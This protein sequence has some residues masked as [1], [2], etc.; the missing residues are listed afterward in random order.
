[1]ANWQTVKFNFDIFDPIKSPVESVLQGLQAVESVLETLLDILKP[2][3]LDIS[4]P[5]SAVIALLLSSIKTIINQLESSGFNILLV[6]PDFS[7]TDFAAVLNSVSGA[8]P[9]FES[10]VV[11]KF[12][13][14]SDIFRPQYPQG[15]TVAMIAF[16][17]GADSPGDLLGLLFNL[18]SIIKYPIT[19]QGLPAPVDLKVRPVLQSGDSISQFSHM[20]DSGIQNQLALEWR[21]PQ[22]ALSSGSTGLFNQLIGF[23]NQFRFPNFII[24]RQGPFPQ[25]DGESEKDPRGDILE[26]NVESTTLGPKVD[27]LTDRYSF[28]RV[29]SSVS[30]REEDGSIYRVFDTKKAIVYSDDGSSNENSTGNSGGLNSSSNS[31]TSSVGTLV[32]GIATGKYKYLDIDLEHGKTYYYRIR[33]FF[34]DATDYINDNPDNMIQKGNQKIIRFENMTLGQPSTVV[35][36]FVPRELPQSTSAIAFQ[37]YD[38]LYRAIQ[39]GVLLNFELPRTY[40]INNQL[41][42]PIAGSPSSLQTSQ[43]GALLDFPENTTRRDEQRTGWGTLGQIGNQIGPLKRVSPGS[44]DLRNNVIFK[45]TCRRLTNTVLNNIISNPELHNILINQWNNSVQDTVE[46][47]EQD[48]SGNRTWGFV[49]IINGITPESAKA[50]DSYLA[51]EDEYSPGTPIS[52]PVPINPIGSN[53]GLNK[54]PNPV[55]V[56]QRQDLSEFLRSALSVNSSNTGYLSWY[57]VS[58]GDMFPDVTPLMFDFEQFLLSLLKAVNSALQEITDIVQTLLAQIRALEQILATILQIIDILSIKV[59]V[60]L[61]VSGPSTNGSSSTLVQDLINS[62]NKPGDSPNGLGSGLIMTFGGPGESSIAAFNAIKF[63]LGLQFI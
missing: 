44:E 36:G 50:I 17:V 30:V 5:L 55:S 14:T 62:T 60:S 41:S 56:Q 58:I 27:A 11:G 28:P 22:Q 16:Y 29:R 24:E 25:E 34:G 31:I 53:T 45:S 54:Q 43:A 7:N 6:H 2:F 47:L 20:F 39:A 57:S 9:G 4:N 10:K 38:D 33:P 52:G 42:T 37:I 63:I 15:S 35:K 49:G 12:F 32:R 1:M 26:V 46:S 19:F 13:D 61:L 23:Y 40:P 59:N 21:M 18:L 8:Y 3:L 48:S 51:L